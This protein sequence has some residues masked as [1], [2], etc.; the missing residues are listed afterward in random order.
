MTAFREEGRLVVVVPDRLSS[1]ERADLVPR[2]VEQFL[3]GEERRRGPRGDAELTSRLLW[4][5]ATYLEPVA[6]RPPGETGARWVGNQL[7]RWGS[8]TPSTGEIRISERLR[9]APSWVLDYVLLHEATHLVERGHTP[10]FH[11]LMASFPDLARARGFLEGVEFSTGLP[12]QGDQSD[13][14]CPGP[15]PSSASSCAS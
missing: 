1:R 5:Y 13:D 7:R 3:A 2:L 14:P 12:Q 9:D 4:L 11:A 8:C 15:P 6:G 10:R